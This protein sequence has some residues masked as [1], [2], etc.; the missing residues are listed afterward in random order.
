MEC[1]LLY[2]PGRDLGDQKLVFVSAINLMDRAELAKLLARMSKLAQYRPVQLHLV[3]LTG[4]GRYIGDII[5][6]VRIRAV[7]IL[8][9]PWGDADRP[10]CADLVIDGLELQ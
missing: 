9:R 6:W 1:Q 10:R 7:Q 3:N 2:P 8:M 5:V 4:D